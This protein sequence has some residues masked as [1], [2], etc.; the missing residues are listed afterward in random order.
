MPFEVFQLPDLDNPSDSP[1]D[2]VWTCS[3]VFETFHG[4][5]RGTYP[6]VYDAWFNESGDRTHAQYT[7]AL[8][9]TDISLEYG[10]PVNGRVITQDEKI[11]AFKGTLNGSPVDYSYR[12]SKRQSSLTAMTAPDVFVEIEKGSS[13]YNNAILQMRLTNFDPPC[14]KP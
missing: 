4:E 2:S 8:S 14:R 10:V 7:G 6:N 12:E 11:Y 1:P 13:E 5:T 9:L 3:N